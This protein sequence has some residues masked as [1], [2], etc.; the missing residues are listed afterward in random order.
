MIYAKSHC[1]KNL[2]IYKT[3]NPRIAIK[4]NKKSKWQYH[5]TFKNNLKSILKKIISYF[6]S[7][8]RFLFNLFRQKIKNVTF[9]KQ[10][11]LIEPVS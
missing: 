5:F 7:L 4:L 3:T 8:R 6:R 11:L 2:F 10:F 9:F 1:K